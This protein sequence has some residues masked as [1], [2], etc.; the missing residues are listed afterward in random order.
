[1]RRV[2]HKVAAGQALKV[3]VAQPSRNE[4][5]N[6]SIAGLSPFAG[7]AYLISLKRTSTNLNLRD[8]I[9]IVLVSLSQTTHFNGYV[10]E[11]LAHVLS[12]LAFTSLYTPKAATE[13]SMMI[14]CVDCLPV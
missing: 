11:I 12:C 10:D 1:M 6:P 14:Y 3:T 9:S 5:L 7:T 4:L 13:L 2:N 8:K